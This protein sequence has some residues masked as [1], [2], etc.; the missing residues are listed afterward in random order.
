MQLVSHLTDYLLHEKFQSGFRPGPSPEASV[1][2]VCYNLLI[3]IQNPIKPG[4]YLACCIGSI[5]YCWSVNV[6]PPSTPYETFS[7]EVNMRQAPLL[8]DVSICLSPNVMN[9]T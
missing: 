6:G 8:K 7:L 3:V 9:G 4:L 1:N 5:W 2:R